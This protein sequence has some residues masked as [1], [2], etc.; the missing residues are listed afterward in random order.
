MTE[1]GGNRKMKG[2]EKNYWEFNVCCSVYLTTAGKG[3]SR[4]IYIFS[5]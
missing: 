3:M 1:E 2:R 5:W 4:Y